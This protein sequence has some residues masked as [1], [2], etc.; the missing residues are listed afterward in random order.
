MVYFQTNKSNLGTFW[1]ALEGK[2][3]VK[4]MA[5]W[6]ILRPFGNFVVVCT[7]F[8]VLVNCLKNNLATLLR[9]E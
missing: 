6:N 4:V 3:L 8:P 9:T 2:M 1:K 5:I 7:F